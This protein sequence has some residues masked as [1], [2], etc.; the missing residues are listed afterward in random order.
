MTLYRALAQLGRLINEWAE[1]EIERRETAPDPIVEQV[2][3][4]WEARTPKR[5]S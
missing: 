5:V 1:R 2:R 3:A 4:S